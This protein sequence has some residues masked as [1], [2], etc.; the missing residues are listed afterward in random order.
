M[1]YS[2][3]VMLEVKDFGSFNIYQ[4]PQQKPIPIVRGEF[5]PCGFTVKTVPEANPA[6]YPMGSGGDSPWVK[7]PGRETNH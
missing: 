7:R 3:L 5:E 4:I 1:T 2:F 6:S